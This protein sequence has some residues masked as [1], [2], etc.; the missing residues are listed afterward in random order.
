MNPKNNPSSKKEKPIPLKPKNNDIESYINNELKTLKG[1]K[2]K[3]NSTYSKAK[4]TSNKGS[5]IR[6]DKKCFKRIN[7]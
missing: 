6:K 5:R 2:K 1:M 7:E 4:S 3:K